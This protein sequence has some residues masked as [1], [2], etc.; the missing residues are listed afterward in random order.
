VEVANNPEDLPPDAHGSFLQGDYIEQDDF[1]R[2]LRRIFPAV[3]G[4]EV[5]LRNAYFVTAQAW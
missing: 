4:K 2:C 5:R 1:G 3:A